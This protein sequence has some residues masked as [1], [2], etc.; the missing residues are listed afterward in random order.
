MIDRRLVLH[1]ARLAHL[2]L[3]DDEVDQYAAQLSRIVD[4]VGVLAKLPAEPALPWRPGGEAS[5]ERPDEVIPPL[6]VEAV[7]ANAPESRDSAFL[8]PKIID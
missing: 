8:V 5:A 6:P 7:L 1:V 2:E 4:Y 3:R